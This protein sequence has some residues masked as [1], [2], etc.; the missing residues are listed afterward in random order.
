VL[1]CVHN[2]GHLHKNSHAAIR[3]IPTTPKKRLIQRAATERR[4][5]STA[6][7]TTVDNP[8]Q[9]QPRR[10]YALINKPHQHPPS[11]MPSRLPD[12][13][14]S[15]LPSTVTKPVTS[16]ESR[17]QLMLTTQSGSFE[18]PLALE[19]RLEQT[20]ESESLNEQEFQSTRPWG[21]RLPH[22]GDNVLVDGGMVESNSLSRILYA[23]PR[24][25]CILCSFAEPWM[26]L[27]ADVSES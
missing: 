8:S 3:K 17:K 11:H 5:S 14:P 9:I 12:K 23:R 13:E 20:E 25:E 21:I 7:D 1:S 26:N 10:S 2:A 6:S 24:D 19:F 18:I 16:P 15:L 27:L 22:Y 4:N